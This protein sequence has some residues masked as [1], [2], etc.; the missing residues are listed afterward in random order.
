VKMK[1]MITGEQRLVPSDDFIS[2][3]E[4]ILR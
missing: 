2:R 1:D 4:S 3:V